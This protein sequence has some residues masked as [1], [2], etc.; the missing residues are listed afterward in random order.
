[1]LSIRIISIG[2]AKPANLITSEL[3][4]AQ[5]NKPVG[6]CYKQSDAIHSRFLPVKKTKRCLGAHALHSALNI[7]L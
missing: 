7:H 5:L 3:L 1:M 4:D 2:K 6:Y